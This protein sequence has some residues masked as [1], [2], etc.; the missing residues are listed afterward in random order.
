[1]KNTLT[2]LIALISLLSFGQKEV[3]N[4]HDGAFQNQL[5][6]E[7]RMP[8]TFV[9][10]DLNY[11]SFINTLRQA[12][13]LTAGNSNIYINLPDENEN[14]TSFKVYNSMTMSTELQNKYPEIGTYR[15]YNYKTGE[16]AS[17]V[18][19]DWGAEIQVFRNRKGSLIIQSLNNS[20]NTYLVYNKK[21]VSAPAFECLV[22]ENNNLSQDF[23]TTLNRS[24]DGLLRKYR[25]G[26]GVTGEYSTY[27]VSRAINAGVI[28]S[29]ATDA[30]KKAVVLAA[31]TTTVDR[32][33]TVYERD[34]GI[35]LE[36][37]QNEDQVIFLNSNTDP[38]D[39]SDI[40]S[41]L[42][43][44]TSVL[45]Q[46]IGTANYDGGHL[47]STYPGG[48]IS[49]LGVICSTNYKA[50]SVTGSTAPIGDSYDIDY[51]AHEVGHSFGANHTFANSCNNNRNMATAVEPGSGQTIMA[52]AGVC[53][54]NTQNHSDDYFHVMSISEIT[55]Y[56]TSGG[57]CSQNMNIGNTAPTINITTYAN[58]Y[59]PK[60]TPFVLEANAT[61]AQNDPLTYCWEEVDALT[62][63]S[64]TSYY[65]NPTY[66]NG[67]M[68]RSYYG[69]ERKQRYF[70][71]VNDILSGSYGN[72][73]EKLPSVNRN[74]NFV[75][76]VRDNHPGGGQSPNMFTTLH[77][78]S[79][80]GPFRVTS[81]GSDE[82]W[83]MGETKTITWDVAGT[84]GGQVACSHVDI[85]FSDNNGV[86][87]DHVLASNVPNDG[88]QSITVP[89]FETPYGRIMVKGHNRYFFDLAKG[90]IS[91]GTFQTTCNTTAS[92]NINLAIPDN[93]PTGVSTTLNVTDNVAISD[94]DVSVNIPHTYI[95]DLTIKVISPSGTEVYLM[96]RTCNN[97]HNVIATFDDQGNNLNCNSI[98]GHVK[99]V[100]LLSNFNGEN[101]QGTW[102][103]WAS[104]SE[105]GD[106]GSIVSWNLNICYLSSANIENSNITD[107]NIWPN[108]THKQVNISF[109]AN[110]NSD[111]NIDIIDISGR[112]VFE[113]TYQ[114]TNSKFNQTIN[115]SNFSKGLYLINIQNG[116]KKSTRKL[117]IK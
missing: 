102:T 59:I 73:W 100:G 57:T 104:D 113:Q 52:Y 22:D 43:A 114:N 85:L 78:D 88:N 15:A 17:I 72:Q 30:Q 91:I 33:N 116:V 23:S 115:T 80:S 19:S 37:V 42:N 69:T 32:L 29:N 83:Q 96:N 53:A 86:T 27:H 99:P 44:N 5:I 46:H 41:M 65:P 77:V 26:V 45:N 20:K 28:P 107:L 6:P 82:V 62:N 36:L 38:Y 112:K 94:I 67:P 75:V 68:F 55:N 9:V 90:K 106:N 31:V 111:I 14:I 71:G 13:D 87:F 97:Q 61:D 2:L 54:P 3:W 34:L 24:N 50:R 18:I 81:Q 12:P 84:T 51:V 48:G 21:F 4:K 101:A 63:S 11:N 103:L 49:G 93:N 92:G 10:Y 60:S 66:T 70:P 95:R 110:N 35:H 64:I 79:S 16:I 98:Q 39:N 40:M 117:I 108:P 7:N 25:Y 74:M 89:S 109:D 58:T 76:T 1:M 56:I 8:S 47:F 105:F